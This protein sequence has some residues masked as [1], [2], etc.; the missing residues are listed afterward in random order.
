MIR[1]FLCFCSCLLLG[2]DQ[3]PVGRVKTHGVIQLADGKPLADMMGTVSFIPVDPS[4]PTSRAALDAGTLP[5]KRC[6]A[7]ITKDGK[8]ELSTDATGDPW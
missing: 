7:W 4:N 1:G 5:G 8:F 2:C 3:T 6:V